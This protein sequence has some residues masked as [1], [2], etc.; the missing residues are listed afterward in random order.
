MVLNYYS[1]RIVGFVFALAVA[2]MMGMYF[3]PDGTLNI[4]SMASAGVKPAFKLIGAILDMIRD[5]IVAI[6]NSI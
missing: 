1:D 2:M 4:I 5:I 6:L 3:F